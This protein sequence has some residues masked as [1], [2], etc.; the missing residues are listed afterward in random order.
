MSGVPKNSSKRIPYN[1][2]APSKKIFQEADFSAHEVPGFLEY[3]PESI[4]HFS[5]NIFLPGHKYFSTLLLTVFNSFAN[6]FQLFDYI[7]PIFLT[8]PFEKQ[9][10]FLISKNETYPVRVQFIPEF[11]FQSSAQR[12]DQVLE[13]LETPAKIQ[14]QGKKARKI[15]FPDCSKKPVLF[16]NSKDICRSKTP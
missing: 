12:N 10:L 4:P 16:E 8:F 3:I 2:T 5:G 13:K 1:E 6:E 15:K 11:C 7:P 14:I 9:G